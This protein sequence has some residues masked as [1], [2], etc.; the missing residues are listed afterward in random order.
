MLDHEGNITSFS[1]VDAYSDDLGYSFISNDERD[2][3]IAKVLKERYK[4]IEFSEIR[5]TYEI[6][7]LY[8]TKKSLI[9]GV[10]VVDS[11]GF[12]YVEVIVIS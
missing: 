2:K 1:K 3:Y 10:S 7:S 11:Q 4:E 9:C 6:L 5:V 8:R 12:S